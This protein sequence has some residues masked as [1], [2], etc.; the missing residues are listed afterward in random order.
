LARISQEV[1]ERFYNLLAVGEGGQ[2]PNRV[3]RY[4]RGGGP[5]TERVCCIPKADL[6]ER[7]G[8][9][10]G[11]RVQGP[12]PRIRKMAAQAADS[13]R[14]DATGAGEADQPEPR[15][16]SHEQLRAACAGE[17]ERCAGLGTTA[18]ATSGRHDR[19]HIAAA[20]HAGQRT[21]C[22]A[23]SLGRIADALADV[24]AARNHFAQSSSASRI[25]AGASGFLN[26]SQSGERP[27][28]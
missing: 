6:L 27:D 11:R 28:R 17:A 7:A 9:K 5:E 19:H 14:D 12:K 3:K 1:T 23:S 10:W 24:F 15:H 22:S 18:T 25:T 26:L 8:D 16:G 2:C 21:K 20:P 13:A 4:R